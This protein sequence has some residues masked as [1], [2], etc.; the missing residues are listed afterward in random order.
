VTPRQ[1]LTA[2][3]C[4]TIAA[5]I[6]CVTATAASLPFHGPGVTAVWIAVAA[7]VALAAVVVADPLIFPTSKDGAA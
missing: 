5:A 3:A 7:V 6:T 4:Y 1:V 2:T